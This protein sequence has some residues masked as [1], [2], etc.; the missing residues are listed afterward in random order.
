MVA[1]NE[2]RRHVTID[3]ANRLS[4]EAKIEV[5]DRLPIPEQDAKVDVVVERVSPDWEKYEQEERKAPIK[6]GYRWQVE[7]PAGEEKTL[8]VEYTIKTFVNN[9]L[10][11]GNRREA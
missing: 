9:E 8:S 1:F 3:V 2:L 5:R 6:G 10:V 4:R 7:V 11:G